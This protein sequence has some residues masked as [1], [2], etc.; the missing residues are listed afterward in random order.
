M[1]G[2]ITSGSPAV[3]GSF[4]YTFSTAGTYYFRSQAVNTM[5]CVVTVRDSLRF[6][7]GDL[8][9]GGNA[10]AGGNVGVGGNLT[11]GGSVQA[12]SVLD[13]EGLSIL[14]QI[15]FDGE[16]KMFL[17]NAC[18][19]GWVEATEL[20]GYFLMGRATGGS[21]RQPASRCVVLVTGA[22]SLTDACPLSGERQKEP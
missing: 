17:T 2:G 5:V 9:L 12:S 7:D 8:S 4:S 20:G 1:V 21:V 10:H 13:N 22:C 14:E 6:G 18:P 16:V 11:V 19:S 15:I 3:A